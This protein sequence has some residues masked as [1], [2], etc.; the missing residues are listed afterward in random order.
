MNLRRFF[1]ALPV[2][3]ILAL[4]GYA[5]GPN[6]E[7]HAVVQMAGLILPSATPTATNTATPTATPTQTSTPTNTATPTPTF[8]PT[9]TRTPPP[10]A[11]RD[12]NLR[13]LRVPI[14]MYHYISV[15]PPDADKYRLDLSVTPANFEA[16]MEYLAV[17]GFTPITVSDLAAH[18]LYGAPLPPKPIALTFDDGYMDNYQ[19]AFPVLKKYKFT[20]TFNVITDF[21]DGKRP[22]YMTW[23]NLEEL[24]MEGMEI[25]SHTISHPD[26]NRKSRAFQLN[27]IAGSKT[28]IESRIGT[29]V[30]TFTYPAGNY[31]ATTLDVLRQ[32]GFVAALSEIQGTRQSTD[33]LLELR[34]IRIRGSYAVAEFGYWLKYFMTYS[35]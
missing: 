22:G 7:P 15:P 21:I 23:N 6:A 20:A 16:Q 18:L 33:N 25:G 8:T 4:A 19:Y 34:R 35:K 9:P 28:I 12:P 29:P 14:L 30:Q 26:L 24:A 1:A 13:G 17:E 3:L 5:V 31:D 10:T 11:T 32:A 27:E 2:A